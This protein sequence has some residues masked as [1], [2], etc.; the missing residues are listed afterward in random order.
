MKKILILILFIGFS[1]NA[2]NPSLFRNGIDT[3]FIQIDT[4][5]TTQRDA[6]VIPSGKSAVIYNS[7]ADSIQYKI[8][9]LGWKNIGG[10]G[11]Q[12]LQQVTDLG[13]ITTNDIFVEAESGSFEDEKVIK[14]SKTLSEN[15]SSISFVAPSVGNTFLRLESGNLTKAVI[16]VDNVTSTDIELQFPD[17]DGRFTIPIL[18]NGESSNNNGEIIINPD[19]LDD[20][21]TTN[22]FVTSIEKGLIDTALQPSNN[23]AELTNFATA[24]SNL[25]LVIGTN[26]LA[27]NGSAA[28][29]TDFPTLNQNTTGSAATLTTART[30]NGTS[31]NGSANITTANWGTSRNISIG[32]TSKAVN[33]SANVTWSTSEIGITKTNIDA[34]NI[35]AASVG[36]VAVTGV[37][38]A[39]QVIK[40]TS[41]T[42]ATWQDESG[43]EGINTAFRSVSTTSGVFAETY[44]KTQ[45][46]IE[47]LLDED[48]YIDIT[49]SDNGDFLILKLTNNDVSEQPFE[50]SL[51]GTE[52]IS[53]MVL[54]GET[55]YATMI[56]YTGDDV[57]WS[58]N[59]PDGEKGNTYNYIEGNTTTE[60]DFKNYDFIKITIDDDDVFTFT[61]PL[62][63]QTGLTLHI[64]NATLL[65]IDVTFPINSYFV[66]E[67][68]PIREITADRI[69][70]YKFDYVDGNFFNTWESVGYNIPGGS[71]EP[72]YGTIIHDSGG[73]NAGTP[74]NI[75]DGSLSTFR[76]ANN[77]QGAYVGQDYGTAKVI[78]K[79]RIYQYDHIGAGALLNGCTI[80]YS[81]DNDS[82]TTLHTISGAVINEWYEQTFTGVSARY[83]R[84]FGAVNGSYGGHPAELEFYEQ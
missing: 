84:L 4:L 21:S 66:G 65:G 71:S 13:N 64:E 77:Q 11:S 42:A 44:N 67:E 35:N 37:P 34:L 25:G 33:G 7:T 53:F 36:G 6:L 48:A 51:N 81:N 69:A 70:I 10:G 31:F 41:G 5:T 32:G 12:N 27:P 72:I 3:K 28:S 30:I 45:P 62:K 18:I 57:L 80:E 76:R 24:R 73:N 29:L 17:N 15:G 59:Y 38:T 26:V 16:A 23:L 50:V 83:W 75:F 14:L 20:T 49:G 46:N 54:S 74:E 47:L 58:V 39:G 22:K 68:A 56:T 63:P 8:P 55:I 78:N 9:G 61:E 43:G 2:Q 79:F 19:D 60:I 1:L 82:W 52:D 40:A